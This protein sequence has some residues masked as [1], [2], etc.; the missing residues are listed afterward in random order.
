M[1]PMTIMPIPI[2]L[3]MTCLATA[4]ATAFLLRLADK[5]DWRPSALWSLIIVFSWAVVIGFGSFLWLIWS[6]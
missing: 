6:L 1:L 3:L 5:E 4:A 2:K